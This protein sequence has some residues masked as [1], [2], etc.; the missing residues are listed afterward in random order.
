MEG[1]GGRI[2]AGSL[3]PMD[4]DAPWLRRIGD[5]FL[6]GIMEEALRRDP[7]D[8]EALAFLAHVH[9]RAG[10]IEEGLRL[11]RRLAALRPGDPGVRYN[12][13]CSLA[14]SGDAEGALRELAEAVRL[15]WDDGGHARVD[16]DLASLRGDPRF[17]ALLRGLG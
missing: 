8:L 5:D 3:L 7:D 6:A 13:A 12:L 4:P 1:G 2:A 15:G 10:R 11:D 9:T 16:E 14:L 17:E